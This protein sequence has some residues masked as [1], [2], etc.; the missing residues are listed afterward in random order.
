M[1]RG[2]VAPRVCPGDDSR[3]ELLR[4][5]EPTREDA[6]PPVKHVLA[7]SLVSSGPIH[8]E[9]RVAL[10]KRLPSRRESLLGRSMNCPLEEDEPDRPRVAILINMR[11]DVFAEKRELATLLSPRR[12]RGPKNGPNRHTY[13][14]RRRHSPP[15]YVRQRVL[16]EAAVGD[17]LRRVTTFSGSVTY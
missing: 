1:V 6:K 3:L 12:W 4:G 8:H 2:E 9:V 10:M 15:A 13:F 7:W 14:A 11:V 16:L 17:R 5:S